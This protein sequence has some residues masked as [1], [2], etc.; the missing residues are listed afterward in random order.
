MLKKCQCISFVW[1][2]NLLSHILCSTT[3]S[4][5]KIWTASLFLLSE[6][7]P[8]INVKMRLFFFSSTTFVSFLCSSSSLLHTS[9]R[10]IH[11]S[12]RIFHSF[13]KNQFYFYWFVE[14]RI[15]GFLVTK[16][17]EDLMWE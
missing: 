15:M 10:H 12:L 4:T 16:H 2:L 11:L 9:Y 8:D 6:I 13:F 7:T 5:N 1:S 14:R 3:Y 17:F